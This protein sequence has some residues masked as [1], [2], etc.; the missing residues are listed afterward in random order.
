VRGDGQGEI[1]NI[2]LRCP[3]NLVAGFGDHY[4]TIDF[5]G[6][7]YFELV[8]PEG[9]RWSDLAWP[10]GDAYTIYRE[11]VDYGAIAAVSIW[12]NRVPAGKRAEVAVGPVMALPITASSVDRPALTIGGKRV[13]FPVRMETGSYLDWEGGAECTVY[14]QKGEVLATAAVQGSATLAPGDN[15]VA[16]SQAESAP[17]NSRSRVT[18]FVHGKPFP[19]NA[20]RPP[21]AAPPAPVRDVN[22]VS[23]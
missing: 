20:K 18:L 7:R 14:G 13:T 17:A 1:L 3:T 5:T 15:A 8:E 12:I 6:W 11:T 23:P 19:L 16:F 10:Y 4:V 9:Q 21:Q 22:A 2:Q